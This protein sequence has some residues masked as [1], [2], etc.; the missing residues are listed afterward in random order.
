MT[1]RSEQPPTSIS[2]EPRPRYRDDLEA[3]IDEFLEGIG[4]LFRFHYRGLI[5]LALLGT[6]FYLW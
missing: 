6:L 2:G 1:V 4:D 3:Q 5:I